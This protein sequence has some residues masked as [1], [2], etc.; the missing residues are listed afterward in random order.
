MSNIQIN[1]YVFGGGALGSW[2]ELGRV[3]LGST[4]YPITVSS[5]PDREFGYLAFPP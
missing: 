4:T 5:L 2:K 1:P 3:T